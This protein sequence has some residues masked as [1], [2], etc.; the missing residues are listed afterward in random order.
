LGRIVENLDVILLIIDDDNSNIAVF[1]LL[2]PLIII[3]FGINIVTYTNLKSIYASNIITASTY[4]SMNLE[5]I[6][7]V[8]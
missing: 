4:Y 5:F 8:K 1:Y 2:L 6:T 3:V 7:K